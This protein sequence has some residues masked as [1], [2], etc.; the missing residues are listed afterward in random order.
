[1]F[2]YKMKKFKKGILRIIIIVGGI[3]S[4]IISTFFFA[5]FLAGRGFE[6]YLFILILLPIAIYYGFKWILEG[7]E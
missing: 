2:V 5:E 4:L 3:W 7:F 1:M 6:T